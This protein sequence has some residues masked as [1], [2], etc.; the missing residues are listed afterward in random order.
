MNFNIKFDN[1]YIKP[2][3]IALTTI[4]T[5]WFI[6]ASLYVFAL[7]K[8]INIQS[9]IPQIQYIFNQKTGLTLEIKN[10]SI[11]TYFSGIF[12]AKAD[13]IGIYDTDNDVVFK[14]STP[15]FKVQPLKLIFKK[16]SIREIKAQDTILNITRFG[17]KEF[18]ADVF[19]YRG[20]K[21]PVE[22]QLQGSKIEIGKYKIF[23]EDKYLK[24]NLSLEGS[25]FVLKPMTRKLSELTTDGKINIDKRTASFNFNII[26]NFLIKDKFN[27]G[28]YSIAGKI[29]NLDLQAFAPYLDNIWKLK[30]AKGII[31]INFSTGENKKNIAEID[32]KAQDISIN[33]GDFEKQ[34]VAK[35][36]TE[37]NVRISEANGDL[38]LEGLK[39]KTPTIELFAKGTIA[40]YLK[41]KPRLNIAATLAPSKLASIIDLLPYGICKEINI[42]KGCGMSADVSGAIKIVGKLPKPKVYGNAEAVNAHALR[43]I[44]KSH[45][46]V[47]K[48]KFEDTLLYSTVDVLTNTNGVFHLTGTSHIY[49]D[50]WDIFDIETKKEI[51]LR[52]VKAIL[53]PVSQLF[54]FPIGPVPMLTVYSGTGTAKMHIKGKRKD[55]ENSKIDGYVDIKGGNARFDGINTLVTNINLPLKFVQDK[56]FFDT[57][58]AYVSGYPLTVTGHCDTRGNLVFNV[59][60]NNIS[61]NK[62][63]NIVNTSEV[64]EDV[65]KAI[66]VLNKVG[67][68]VKFTASLK[69]VIDVKDNFFEA[70]QKLAM[71]GNVELKNNTAVLKG[72]DTPFY[73]ANGKIHFTEKIAEAKGL[74]IKF[75]G[76]GV[77]ADL[78]SDIQ[79]GKKPTTEIYVTGNSLNTYDTVCLVMKSDIARSMGVKVNKI[80]IFRGKHTLEF[81]S[82]LNNNIPDLNTIQAEIK[83]LPSVQGGRVQVPSGEINVANGNVSIKNLNIKADNSKIGINGTVKHFSA[84]NPEYNI[85]AK[86]SDI[87]VKTLTDLAGLFPPQIK[88]SIQSCKDYRGLLGINLLFTAKGANGSVNLKDF[89]FRHIKSDVPVYFAYLP[90]KM[91]TNRIS[92][93][94]VIGSVGNTG[95]SPIFFNINI[96]NYMKIPIVKGTLAAKTNPLFIERY[97]NTKLSHPI[98]ASGEISL[99]AEINGSIDSLKILPKIKLP[100]ETD[101]TYLSSNFGDSDLSR[102][103]KGELI[104]HPKDLI[105]K[106]LEYIKFPTTDSG[107]TYAMPMWVLNGKADL[108][109]GIYVPTNLNFS[110]YRNLPAKLLN[111]AFKKSL[112]KS[113][114][115][116]CN[117]NY[118]LKNNTPK[119]IGSFNLE[120]AGIPMYNTIIK[121]GKARINEENIYLTVDGN[122]VN[123]SYSIRSN[124]ANSIKKPYRIK[125]LDIKSKQM[126]LEQLVAVIYKWS[127]DAYMNASMNNTVNVDISDFTIDKGIFSVD[128][129]SYKTCP[130]ENFVANFD[131]NKNSVL[132]INS[133]TFKMTGGTV[134]G[135]LKY[136]F[137]NGDTQGNLKIKGIDSNSAAY[138]FL[139]LKNQIN[140]RLDGDMSI[141]TYGIEDMERLKNLNGKINFRI[142]H[143]NMPKLGSLEYLLR[144]GNLLKSGLTTLSVNGLIDLLKPFKQGSF[145]RITGFLYIKNGNINN[146]STYSQGTNMSLYMTGDYNIAD[147]DANIVIFGKLGKKI[148][149]LLGPVGN[150]STNTLFNLI[151]WTK[152][153]SEYTKEI[154]KIPNI[155]YQNQDVRV[156]RATVNGNINETNSA[157]SFKW[158]R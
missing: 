16:L 145:T 18:G 15:S 89:G 125:L 132:T 149:G 88:K 54:D 19:S 94:N 102:E 115:F 73:G 44:E 4:I 64:L 134:N 120:N 128:K 110:T 84:K 151:P 144:A 91:T 61:A 30:N 41:D 143:G 47:I 137:Q 85:S 9:R 79:K 43:G 108:I 97:I 112:I 13:E 109:K 122:S 63:L 57:K 133:E 148:D 72:F 50:D 121:S 6:T 69:G 67:G 80:P 118:K 100:K 155:E 29:T 86:G 10:P 5:I 78:K 142:A 131:L 129:I 139:G 37:L 21:L 135:L 8:V 46:A 150:V 136:N 42:L 32:V 95:R 92:L 158:V 40:D 146:F 36:K 138:S 39:F 114:E 147:A 22:I 3:T 153:N 87:S 24:K 119:I 105:I 1:K 101:I 38:S 103:I 123:T 124:I 11:K 12:S 45:S 35:G 66:D 154:Q 55:K 93:N 116:N 104:L 59:G 140:G 14:T 17:N 48:L 113:G 28:D 99:N 70:I 2:I 141:K 77:S 82:K 98:K 51:D 7:P 90:I 71:D 106:K 117:L 20:K 156:F 83:I 65:K 23:F 74:K 58:T 52:L 68:N 25:E 107:R 60:S 53:V 33:E 76:S 34:F 111:F 31:N 157:T 126:D 56:I 130:I 96:D 62:L 127:L 75:G 49:E 27:F 26:S 81:R 152:E